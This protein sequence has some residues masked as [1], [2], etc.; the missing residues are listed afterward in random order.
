MNASSQHGQ[1]AK[2]HDYHANI[3]EGQALEVLRGSQKRLRGSGNERGA[4]YKCPRASKRAP[5]LHHVHF[6][7]L[8]PDPAS[9]GD[10]PGPLS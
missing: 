5:T 4:L 10:G 2:V 7:D 6:A 1:S 8:V 3:P 9:I